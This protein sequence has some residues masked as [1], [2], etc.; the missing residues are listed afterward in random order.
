MQTEMPNII[1]VHGLESSGQG[2]KGQLLRKVFPGCLTPDFRK[3]SPEISY[4]ALLT[5]R[6]RELTQ[7]LNEKKSWII[8]GSSFG[9]LMGA[10]FTCQFP[11]KIDLL[12]LLAPALAVPE[13]EPKGFLEIEVPVIV[14]HGKRDQVVSLRSSR[15]RAIKL[16]KNLNYNIVDD[17]HMLHSTV[18]DLD[19]T[20]IINPYNKR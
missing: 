16:F 11:E 1:F 8:I 5:E 13:L 7:I 15:A 19:W 6:M 3:Y 4:K 17:D 2:F 14:Y 18:K 9:G 10:L 20:K 12:I